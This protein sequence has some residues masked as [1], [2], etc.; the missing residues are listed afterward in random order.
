[1]GINGDKSPTINILMI[2]SGHPMINGNS[3]AAKKRCFCRMQIFRSS[4][5]PW[6][7]RMVAPWPATLEHLVPW[8]GEGLWCGERLHKNGWVVDSI[9]F[10]DD[11]SDD[12][13]FFVKQFRACLKWPFDCDAW[14]GTKVPAK[15]HWRAC[16]NQA[17]L[18]WKVRVCFCICHWGMCGI[19]MG[20]D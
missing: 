20:Q 18:R 12:S 4:R 16:L 1:M 11:H 7:V 15:D 3:S 14:P 10:V 6:E 17:H 2:Q 8:Y 9:S 5:F 19:G 13:L